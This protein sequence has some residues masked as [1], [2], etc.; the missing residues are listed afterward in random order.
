MPGRL[1]RIGVP[2]SRVTEATRQAAAECVHDI[3]RC[4]EEHGY[5]LEGDLRQLFLD[6]I[7]TKML[8][9]VVDLLHA[10]NYDFEEG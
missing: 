7:H 3:R 2:K 9:S 8:M 4:F 5:V 6:T 1:N 10:A